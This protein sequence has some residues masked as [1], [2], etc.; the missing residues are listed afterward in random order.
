VHRGYFAVWRKIQDHKFYK[1][2]RI[3]SKFE[4]WLDILMEA[5]F[6]KEPKEVLLK[7]VLLNQHYGEVLRSLRGW[8]KRWQWSVG[9]VTR[10]LLLL[11]KMNQIRY[12]NE[13]VT[14]RITV[15]NYEKYDIRRNTSGTQTDTRAEHERNA[16]GIR[17]KNVKN[18]EDKKVQIPLS[19]VNFLNSSLQQKIEYLSE[20]NIFPKAEI[21]V[22]DQKK[23][24]RNIQAIEHALNQLY[25][26][27]KDNGFDK[28][29][30]WGYCTKIVN[31]ESQNYNERDAVKEAERQ[32]Q[33][34]QELYE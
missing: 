13:T 12:R 29:G 2:K 22:N 25:G 16:G 23:R 4:A 3:Y 24:N 26:K 31:V 14:T 11:K 9:R 33:A 1:E 20:N 17:L 18:V 19:A 15:L 8:S 30:A 6:Q 28:A 10:F 34:L 32:K 7:M 21:F 5:Q 27:A